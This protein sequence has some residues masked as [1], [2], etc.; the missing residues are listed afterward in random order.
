MSVANPI[1]TIRPDDTPAIWASWMN[2]QEAATAD[3]YRRNP[4][5][6]LADHG[7]EESITRDYVGRE[8]LELLSKRE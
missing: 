3:E 5:R 2:E 7:S 1:T 4:K 6:L 8:I